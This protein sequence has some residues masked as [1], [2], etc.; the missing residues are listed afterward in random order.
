[1]KVLLTMAFFFLTATAA[2]AD[3]CS[4]TMK[5]RYSTRIGSYTEYGYTKNEACREALRECNMEKVRR[6]YDSRYYGAYCE[7]DTFSNPNP[8]P[9]PGDRD[10][11]EYELRTR[12][13]RVIDTFVGRGRHSGYACNDARRECELKL[14]QLN[15]QGRNQQAYCAQASGRG[16]GRDRYET[17]TCSVERVNTRMGRVIE[18]HTATSTGPR[19]SDVKREACSQAQRECEIASRYTSTPDTCVIRN[20]ARDN[21]FD[22]VIGRRF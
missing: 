1:M 6:D 19:G 12:N 5:D 20:N 11:C 8:F 16:D 14:D 9:T 22:V 3:Y 10:T 7:I 13:G 4:A 15:R 18:I 21:D 2:N 17:Q